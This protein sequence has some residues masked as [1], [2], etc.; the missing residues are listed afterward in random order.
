MAR[1]HTPA[2]QYRQA[3]QMA[4]DHNLLISEKPGN[5]EARYVV[6]RKTGTKPVF[7]GQTTGAGGLFRLV[8]KF[9]H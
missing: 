5:G 9:S 7:L 6:Y 2:E 8:S 3:Q 4:R 1:R